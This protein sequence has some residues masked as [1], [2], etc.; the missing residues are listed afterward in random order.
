MIPRYAFLAVLSI[1]ALTAAVNLVPGDFERLAMLER[2]GRHEQALVE[3]EA[4]YASGRRDPQLVLRLY[5]LNI[6]FGRVD[7]AQA[8][9]EEYGRLRPNDIE[10]QIGLIRFYQSNQLEGHYVRALRSLQERTR[11]R[12]LLVELLGFFRMTGRFRE[13]EELLESTARANRAGPSELERLGLLAAARGDLQRAAVALRRADGRLDGQS[14]AARIGLFRVLME[15]KETNEAHQRCLA[16]L[17]S[18][19]DPELAIELMGAFSEAGRRDL[20]VDIGARFGGAG[21]EVTLTTAELLNEQGKHAE[22]LQRLRE[23]Q[24]AGLPEDTDHAQRFV[25]VAASSGD[26]E[27]ALRAARLVGLRRLEGS[28]IL[29]LLDAIQD[30]VD[31]GANR[32]PSELLKGLAA[33][34][35]ARLQNVAPV[36]Q[37]AADQLVLG[38]EARLFVTQM[39]IL[40]KDKDLA[41][42]HLAAVDPDRL[43]A[44]ELSRWTE[45]Q[46]ATGLRST[47]FP[48]LPRSWRRGDRTN[49]V[50]RRMQRLERGQAA[51]QQAGRPRGPEAAANSSLQPLPAAATGKAAR[52]A[53][54]K[55]AASQETPAAKSRRIKRRAAAIERRRER[56]RQLNAKRN[57]AAQGG[58]AAKAGGLSVPSSPATLLPGPGAG[59]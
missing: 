38:D 37:E 49:T 56:T 7:E 6:R 10:A 29:D 18:W 50:S 3:L 32:F 34:I 42:K 8:V 20:A 2:D 41:R 11:S 54:N 43:N 47:A 4:L 48:N 30:A 52:E 36:A 33:E 15:L 21:S 17:R 12:E 59:G 25:S 9:L 16:W 1:G 31:S 5:N 46:A 35:E 14:R 57:Q 58:G 26:P 44:F 53:A 19:R 40:D 23:Y 24:A 39:A 13:E 28:V 55:S 22:A 51:S 45:L 27:M